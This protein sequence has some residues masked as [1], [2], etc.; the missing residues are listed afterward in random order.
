MSALTLALLLGIR[1]FRQRWPAP[2]IAMVV[3][4]YL[5]WQFDLV[6]YGI[7]IVDK[8]A[9]TTVISFYP[10]FPMSGFHLGSLRELIVPSINLAVISFVSFYDDGKKFC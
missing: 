10:S 8:E 4:T 1:H 3:M 9:E 7:A 6:N 2:L 5:S